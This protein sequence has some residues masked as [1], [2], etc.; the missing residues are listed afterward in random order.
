MKY[1]ISVLD[2]T[3]NQQLNVV[4]KIPN[5]LYNKDDT[6]ALIKY[7]AEFGAGECISLSL[8]ATEMNA[9]IENSLQEIVDYGENK[10]YTFVEKRQCFVD[11][12]LVESKPV[13]P[14]TKVG[15]YPGNPEFLRYKPLTN[16]P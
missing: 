13:P 9:D 12:S 8:I 7:A 16:Q 14:N 10:G 2:N 5:E 6:K 1:Q 4:I 11:L 3:Q 15:I